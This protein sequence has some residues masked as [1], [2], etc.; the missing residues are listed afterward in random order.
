MNSSVKHYNRDAEREGNL[1]LRERESASELEGGQTKRG[2]F[3]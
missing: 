3:N 1:R 2:K